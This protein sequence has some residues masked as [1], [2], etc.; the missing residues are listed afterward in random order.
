MSYA[1]R[2]LSLFAFIVLFLSAAAF[3]SESDHKYEVDDPVTFWVNK[4]GPY[5]NPQET[6]NY[7]SLPFCRPAGDPAHKWGGLGEV[8]GGN[9]LIDSRV[10]IKFRKN[11]DKSLICQLPLTAEKVKQFK[12]AI[13]NSYWLEF[14][15]DDLPLWGFVGELHPDKNSDNNKHVL[16]THKSITVKYNNDQIIHVNLSQEAPKPLEDGTTL[17]MTYSV[18]WVP[19]NITFGRRF[20]VY[21]DY[22]FFEHQIH[23]FSIFNSFMMVIFLTGLVSMILMRT[24]RNDYAKY[25]REDDDLETLERDVS[26]ESGWKLVHGDVFRPPWNLVVLSA[27][28]GTGAQL[29]LLVLL[30]ILLAIVGTLY[31]GRGAIVTTF[32]VC[33]ALTSFISGY[34]SGGMYSRHGGK[35]WIKSMILTA[36][37]FPF[38]CF[39]IGF[40]LNTI[41]IFYGSLA[42]I[43]FGTMVVVF[44]IWAFISFPLALLG[45]VVG[46]NWSGAPNNPC[47]VKTIPRPIPEKKW[48][49]TPS[50]VSMMGGLLPFGSIFIEMYFVFTSFWNYKVYYVYGFMLLVFLILIIVTVCVTIVGTY[51]LL[52]A[53]NYH[54]QW[55]SFFSAAST[56]VYVYFYSIYYY[57]VKTKMFGFFQTSF[58]FGYTLMFCL[59]LGIL[60][61]AVGY[62]GSNLFVRRIYRNIKCD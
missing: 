26:E 13:E 57:Y 53:E 9:E 15:M 36:S 59:G 1:G 48:Y 20:D 3:A 34:V 8:L 60:C 23:W 37:L 43:P 50:V 7:Y 11:V 33:Y 38:M 21:L 24:L 55:T 22:P 54:W 28:V 4:V 39:G 5:N 51:F 56:A 6:Y 30:V 58:Y 10:S 18:K 41:A 14:F 46:R 17:D 62:L 47:R 44:V 52:N 12:D 25:A 29:A 35:S 27:V 42:A 32:I 31:V 49:L 16:Y 40:I 19:T 45:T 61:G 2:F